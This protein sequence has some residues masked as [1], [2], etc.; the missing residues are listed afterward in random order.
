MGILSGTWKK[1]R[2]GLRRLELPLLH[3][4]LAIRL[5]LHMVIYVILKISYPT[6]VPFILLLVFL[7]FLV[8]ILR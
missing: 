7:Q 8:I 4:P 2:R 5:P 1:G 3:H 6:Q